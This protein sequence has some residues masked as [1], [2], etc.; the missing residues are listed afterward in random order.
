[1]PGHRNVNC[2]DASTANSEATIISK[3]AIEPECETKRVSLDPR[4]LDRAIMISQDLSS[5][6]ETELLSLLEK[7]S[8]VFAWQTSDLM[9]VSKSIIEHRAPS[10]P[11]CKPR[12]QKLC[13]M[14]DEKVT[15]S[16]AEV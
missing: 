12:K 3:P 16:K 5:E 10:Q 15:T 6:E 9:G 1:V 4:A 8:D 2:Y 11:L 7:N 13:K 14:S